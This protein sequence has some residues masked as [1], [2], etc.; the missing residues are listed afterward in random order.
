MQIQ[1]TKKI[2]SNIHQGFLTNSTLLKNTILIKKNIFTALS[3]KHF[4]TSDYN[5]SRTN[6]T[7]FLQFSGFLQTNKLGRYRKNLKKK[8]N[9]TK[10]KNL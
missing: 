10:K 8:K 3:K 6:D 5:I 2:K 4:I 7:I 1:E 9:S